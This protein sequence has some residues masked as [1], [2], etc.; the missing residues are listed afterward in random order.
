[1]RE[2][3]KL[4]P[5]KNKI[6]LSAR[7]PGPVMEALE[8]EYDLVAPRGDD[9]LAGEALFAALKGAWAFCPVYYDRVDAGFLAR[10]PDSVKIIASFGV[11]VDH[12]D[13]AAAS[14]RKLPVSNTPDVLT[15]D[16]A[17]LT[18]GLMI[19]AARGFHERET[20]LR[21]G[22]WNGSGVGEGLHHR[23]SGKT[24]GI[25][26]MGRIGAAVASRALAF[27]M[28]II[29]HSRSRKP[30]LEAK[31]GPERLTWCESIDE[32]LARADFVSLHTALTEDTRHLMDA[33]RLG[34]MKAG[35]YLIN[36]GRGGLIDEAALVTALQ[37]GRPGGAGLDVYEFEPKL[38]TGLVDLKNVTLLPHIGSA[39]HDTRAAMGM[40]V[41]ENLDSYRDTG[42][43][44]D[45]VT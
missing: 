44:K 21:S 3:K 37:A 32:L 13:L 41:K 24:L 2:S 42:A 23:V 7:W 4:M 29:Y 39:T 30:E 36:T 9:H 18:I 35:A 11:G 10:L 33:R 8:A 26:G 15:D 38:A 40:R 16:T 43:L 20:L 22:A 5:D 31:L 19:A 34:L 14:A 25:I 45:P 17:D 12:M 27:H 28:R 6:V 1:M